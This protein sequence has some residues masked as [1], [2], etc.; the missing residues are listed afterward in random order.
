MP[1]ED[2]TELAQYEVRVAAK[3][4]AVGADLASC[5]NDL[6]GCSLAPGA[7]VL[8]LISGSLMEVIGGGRY[9]YLASVARR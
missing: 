3:I 6:A 5:L 2:L 4:L 9:T 8:D 7:V 1:Q